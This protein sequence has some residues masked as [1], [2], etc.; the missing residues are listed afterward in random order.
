MANHSFVAGRFWGCRFIQLHNVA[1]KPPA[2]LF[3]S[4]CSPPPPAPR[5]MLQVPYI[6]FG[7]PGTGKTSTV[8]EAILQLTKL[9][10]D[11]KILVSQRANLPS[12][13]ADTETR[14]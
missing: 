12:P 10:P 1:A 5:M 13:L 3:S 11:C 6:I 4:P 14:G 8:I 9:K 2:G 7:P